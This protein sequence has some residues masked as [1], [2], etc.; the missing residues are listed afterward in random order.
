MLAVLCRPLVW[1]SHPHSG[2]SCFLALIRSCSTFFESFRPPGGAYAAAT[3]AAA[4]AEAEAAAAGLPPPP[5]MPAPLSTGPETGYVTVGMLVTLDY[6]EEDTHSTERDTLERRPLPRGPLIANA[7]LAA[8]ASRSALTPTA[9]LATAQL[10]GPNA[11]PGDPPCTFPVLLLSPA[12]PVAVISHFDLHPAVASAAAWGMALTGLILLVVPLG[13]VLFSCD[14]RHRVLRPME[15]LVRAVKQ[16]GDDALLPRPSPAQ[17]TGG[18][19]GAATALGADSVAPAEKGTIAVSSSTTGAAAASAFK[20][21]SKALDWT[22]DPALRAAEL[23]ALLRSVGSMGALLRMGVGE[24]GARVLAAQQSAAR[25]LDPLAPG[26]RSL[27][28]FGCVR[29]HLGAPLTAALGGEVVPLVNAIADIVHNVAASTRVARDDGGTT[30]DGAGD[31]ASPWPGGGAGLA[32]HTD[33]AGDVTIRVVWPLP[34]PPSDASWPVPSAAGSRG[35]KLSA[36]AVPLSS[37]AVAAAARTT[38][39]STNSSSEGGVA[40]E[41]ATIAS[42]RGSVGSSG[43]IDNSMCDED[44]LAS[45]MPSRP[46]SVSTALSSA[47]LSSSV[48][49][50]PAAA[51]GFGASAAAASSSAAIAAPATVARS[52]APP[53]DS[54]LSRQRAAGAVPALRSTATT[55]GAALPAA[56][57]LSAGVGSSIKIAQAVPAACADDSSTADHRQSFVPASSEISFEPEADPFCAS[58]AAVADAA[59]GAAA[60]IVLELVQRSASIIGSSSSSCSRE[61]DDTETHDGDGLFLDAESPRSPSLAAAGTGPLLSP[62]AQRRLRALLR[63]HRSSAASAPLTLADLVS[64][65]LHAGWAVDAAVGSDRKLDTDAASPHARLA[66][67]LASQTLTVPPA[68]RNGVGNVGAHGDED[69]NSSSGSSGAAGVVVS[70][71]LYALLSPH[72]RAALCQCQCAS[73]A[74]AEPLQQS[75]MAVAAAAESS[76]DALSLWRQSQASAVCSATTPLHSHAAGQVQVDHAFLRLTGCE[77]R[78]VPLGCAVCA[79][80]ASLAAGGHAPAPAAA[81]PSAAEAAAAGADDRCLGEAASLRLVAGGKLAISHAAA[82]ELLLGRRAASTT[83][84]RASFSAATASLPPLS[85]IAAALLSGGCACPCPA[86][87][88]PYALPRSTILRAAAVAGADSSVRSATDNDERDMAAAEAASVDT[89]AEVEPA[90]AHEPLSSLSSPQAAAN[91]LAGALS[92]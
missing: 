92:P 7:S 18:K 88:A 60:R 89:P 57:V 24:H 16:L 45:A 77:V 34:S 62:S 85:S 56:P 11:K 25:E 6:D 3:A 29:L 49:P 35:G 75:A 90:P 2:C 73:T 19:G 20:K 5:P 50:S 86:C 52:A 26:K 48:N 38:T 31:A 87:A 69:R 33:D 17:V 9:G 23:Q 36:S 72:T 51:A 39:N 80:L 21:R 81:A 84:V 67:T 4:L 37:A 15:A 55:A 79:S 14:V 91:P 58:V 76:S 82:Q 53:A 44:L 22:V 8:P 41:G 61:G 63:G 78:P 42:G 10:C 43:S 83:A 47:A 30:D 32:L 54:W 64:V 70:R 46:G 28:I 66:Q 1:T 59:L 68:D 40:G 12:A 27:A 13:A 71:S 74:P 65:S